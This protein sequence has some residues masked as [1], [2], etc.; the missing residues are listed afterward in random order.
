MS[1]VTTKFGDANG[2]ITPKMVDY[3]TERARGGAAMIVTEAFYLQPKYSLGNNS[4][5]LNNDSVI[6][7]LTDLADAIHLYGSKLCVQ[8][9]AG[10][11]RTALVGISAENPPVSAS[12]VPSFA[13][14][15]LICREMT[16][17]EIH[18]IIDSFYASALRV[19]MAGAD[20]INIHAHNGYLIDQFMS[21][22]WNKRTDEYG[23]NFE[24][25]MRFAVEIIQ[26]IRKAVGPDFP[27][28]FRI[29][30]DHKFP[31]GR[32]V[33]ESLEILKYLEANGVDALDIDSGCYESLDY[34]FT[35]YYL[36]DAC[37]MYVTQKVK[38]SGIQ[39]PLLN[40]GSHTPET[41]KKAVE[42]GLV[43][44][45]MIGR[46]MIADPQFANKLRL[47]DREDIR[48]CLRC[49]EECT[50]R[51][52]MS[53]APISCAV[54]C[55]VGQETRAEIRPAAVQKHIA[56]IGGGPAGLEAA[57]VAALQGHTVDL[58]EQDSALGGLVHYIDTPDFKTQMLSLV[59]WYEYQMSKLGVNVHLNHT[60]SLETDDFSDADYIFYA[61][62]AK[63]I[64]PNIKGIDS[65]NVE[66]VIEAHKHT[67]DL[68]HNI[69]I[70]GGG[71]SGCDLGLEIAMTGR[72][73]TIVEM[74]DR[75]A[76]DLFMINQISLF[77][78]FAEN[79]IQIL[80]GHKVIEISDHELVAEKTGSKEIVRI[81]ADKII[82]SFGSKPDRTF[83]SQ[84]K[85]KYAGKVTVI[86]D[87]DFPGKI[88]SAVR[89]G[90][91]AALS[92]V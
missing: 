15:N 85:E 75:V 82:Y 32:T 79:N 56:I 35:P 44:L 41:A 86:G 2:C 76:N 48:P 12:A 5:I 77:T 74:A 23:G 70:A 9:G 17:D 52:M 65:P 36:G 90:F 63:S 47:G 4:I 19:K 7:G 42:D 38:E 62:G 59:E 50:K 51:L 21:S 92:I 55:Q 14:P 72:Q 24:N 69:V 91:S 10:S 87:A 29:T 46:G 60:V 83:E 88:S 22:V 58:F 40:A 31:G 28:I 49:N 53:L 27:I 61:G 11:G 81:P 34:I 25:R 67:A 20:A 6:P 73:V 26:S 18:E 3:Y 33:D 37:E 68:P 54:N 30:L 78:K 71:L 43:D 1:P 13:N 16:L 66:N 45:V 8:I 89:A 84:L 80:T 64:K 39:I 57:R